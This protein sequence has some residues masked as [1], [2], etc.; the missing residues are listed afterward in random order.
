MAG[1]GCCGGLGLGRRD[2]NGVAEAWAAADQSR[3]WGLGGGMRTGDGTDAG[4]EA[5]TGTGVGDRIGVGIG[6]CDGSGMSWRR[7]GWA[8]SGDGRR[9]RMVARGWCGL[10]RGLGERTGGEEIQGRGHS[11]GWRWGD[12][13]GW[14]RSRGKGRGP[15]WDRSETRSGRVEDDAGRTDWRSVRIRAG[16]MGGGEG[17]VDGDRVGGLGWEG[18]AVKVGPCLG[19]VGGGEGWG[20]SRPGWGWGGFLGDGWNRVG[21][22]ICRRR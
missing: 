22:G 7:G 17:W 15:E 12:S 6:A 3:G 2:G 14:G 18:L 21:D 4:D 9:R 16:D 1:M 10:G 8:K 13:A 11:K 20:G 5:G 19:D